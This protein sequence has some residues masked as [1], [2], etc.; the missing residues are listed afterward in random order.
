[1]TMNYCTFNNSTDDNELLYFS[2]VSNVENY[3]A[4]SMQPL[5]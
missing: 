2:K 5:P 3:S 4:Q 1:M